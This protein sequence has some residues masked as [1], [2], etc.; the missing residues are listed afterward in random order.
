[1]SAASNRRRGTEYIELNT[2]NCEACWE[3][4]EACPNQVLGKLQ[5]LSHK[6]VRVVN[7]DNCAGCGLCAFACEHDAIRLLYE[8]PAT[9]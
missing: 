7:A 3:C 4:V 2:R 9:R 1:M 8:E 6:H 5:V